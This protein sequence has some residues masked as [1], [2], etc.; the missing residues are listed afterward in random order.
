MV[1]AV[2]NVS[3][4][5]SAKKSP[6]KGERP[7]DFSRNIA[8]NSCSREG[9]EIHKP[10]KKRSHN[11]RGISLDVS[12]DSNTSNNPPAIEVN[13]S[14]EIFEVEGICVCLL[15]CKLPSILEITFLILFS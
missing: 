12:I 1:H 4:K 6:Q 15:P 9:W 2:E 3:A 13:L 8:A 10:W 5:V 14:V 11:D 7:H